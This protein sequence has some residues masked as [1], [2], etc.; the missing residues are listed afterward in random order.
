MSDKPAIPKEVERQIYTEARHCC[1]ICG[2]PKPVEIHHIVPW[3]KSHDSRAENLI[4]LCANHHRQAD[5]DEIDRSSL[6]GYKRNPFAVSC[7]QERSQLELAIET[8]QVTVKLT[9]SGDPA[10]FNELSLRSGVAG[11]TKAVLESIC[12]LER[13]AGSVIVTLEL[14]RYAA[15]ILVDGFRQE[16]PLLADFL[17][18][19][20]ILDLAWV[21]DPDAE[22]DTSDGT[23]RSPRMTS[24]ERKVEMAAE[25]PVKAVQKAIVFTHFMRPRHPAE[26]RALSPLN[27]GEDKQIRAEFVRRF[28]TF[29]DCKSVARL[30]VFISEG[31]QAL[32]SI[33][34]DEPPFLG[35]QTDRRLVDIV[36]EAAEESGY[37]G[38]VVPIGIDVLV[39]VLWRLQVK[40]RLANRDLRLLLLGS[41]KSMRYDSPKMVEAI[42]RIAGHGKGIPVFRIDEDVEG[43][44]AA[45]KKLI[46][47]YAQIRATRSGEYHMY[48]M[49]SGGYG[50]PGERDPAVRILNDYAVRAWHFAEPTEGETSDNDWRIRRWSLSETAIKE[51]CYPFLCDLAKIGAKQVME[52]EDDLPH[53]QVISG[54]GLCLSTAAIQKL[55]PFANL[56]TSITWIDDHLKRRMHATLGDL[57]ENEGISRVEDAHFKQNRYPNGIR[58]R[59]MRF[60]G[61]T[62]YLCNVARGCILDALIGRPG[63]LGPYTQLISEILGGDFADEPRIFNEARAEDGSRSYPRKLTTF[64]EELLGFGNERISDVRRCW[65]EYLTEVRLPEQKDVS[66]KE[67]FDRVWLQ[68]YV[69]KLR[70]A[71]EAQNNLVYRVLED[72]EQYLELLKVWPDFVGMIRH[73]Q[74][75][76]GGWV[77][78]ELA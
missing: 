23:A 63:S 22:K 3:H 2:I 25:H 31:Y 60:G 58:G 68:P 52:S 40:L 10:Q 59:D 8:V 47:Q 14:P 75:D 51:K 62:A 43:N 42:L 7:A 74:E 6:R 57:G 45:F 70:T 37:M 30:F 41:G 17:D 64:G 36:R 38:E 20:K 55:P 19:M 26:D 54:A 12:V 18:P 9:V 39:N 32:L 15:R 67:A 61:V 50:D 77:L 4:L 27:H 49:F 56:D 66:I 34:A 11:Y 78:D 29:S 13:E 21:D 76:H 1:A 73:L 33:K 48:Y 71:E 24:V 44:E 16:D 53:L 5:R 46:E 72:A 65:G 28:N 35:L 69:P